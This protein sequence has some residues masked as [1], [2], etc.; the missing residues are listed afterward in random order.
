MFVG[1]AKIPNVNV[2]APK[3]AEYLG[4][5]PNTFGGELFLGFISAV[6]FATILAVVAGLT[7]AAS[8][9]FAHDFWMNVVKR[10]KESESEQILVAR[11][12]AVVVG[13]VSVAV[14]INLPT[15]N[16]A[17]LVAVAFAVASSG[18][19]PV[20]LF[21]LF[22][23]RFNTFGAVTGLLGGTLVS[24]LLVIIGPGFATVPVKNPTFPL[25][26]PGIVSIPLGFV[27]AIAGTYVGELFGQDRLA[28]ARFPEI[29][30]RSQTGIGA[31]PSGV[32]EPVAAFV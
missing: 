9:A 7:L 27:F 20:I 26:N 10:G 13:I 18:N 28:Q 30:V 14:A 8:S 32:A 25:A 11:I 24:V 6:A 22:W 12:A 2:A 1:R 3:L 15:A 29:E 21:A 5:G 23:K 4:G 17:V 31:E 16:A 19:L